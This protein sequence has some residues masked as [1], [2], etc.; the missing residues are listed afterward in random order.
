VNIKHGEMIM[1]R[2]ITHQV[3]IP[4][5]VTVALYAIAF[6]LMANVVKPLL[7]ADPA[8]AAGGVAKMAICDAKGS[9]CAGVN[10]GWLK[11]M[12]TK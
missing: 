7:I 8:W 1:D 12:N 4:T 10:N 2:K 3:K 5:V 11:V 6:G 9:E